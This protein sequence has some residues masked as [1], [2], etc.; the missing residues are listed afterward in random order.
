[1]ECVRLLP[2]Q[3]FQ[4]RI[5]KA[6][7]THMKEIDVLFFYS[8]GR[9][10]AVVAQLGGFVACVPTLQDHFELFRCISCGVSLEPRRFHKST[11]QRGGK[12]LVLARKIEWPKGFAKMVEYL[13]WLS[14]WMKSFASATLKASSSIGC[15][16]HMSFV[17]LCNCGKPNYFPG[18]QAKNMTNQIVLVQSLH[19]QHNASVSLVV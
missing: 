18:L 8:P 2:H 4:F 12:L 1:M 3:A 11:A 10:H 16:D 7:A 17:L 9:T 19:D 6:L 13:E 15:L 5:T 14:L